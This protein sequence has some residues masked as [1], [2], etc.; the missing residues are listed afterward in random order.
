MTP[1]N[2]KKL[3]RLTVQLR[4]AIDLNG[5]VECQTQPETFYPEDWHDLGRS[6]MMRDLATKTAK[7]ICMRC[8]VIAECLQ[9]GVYE[10]FGIWGGT[11]P[12]QR[13]KIR[14]QVR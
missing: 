14:K 10:D 13:K 4:E 8:P 9:V 11:T 3:D 1:D 12:D 5:G 2:S 7:E 6:T